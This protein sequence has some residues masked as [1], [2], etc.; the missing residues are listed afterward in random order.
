M[1]SYK[2][3][4][5]GGLYLVIDPCLGLDAILPKL[6]KAIEGGI[7]VLQIWNNWNSHQNKQELLD[8][9]CSIA[10]ANDIPV[11]IN[12]EWELMM[13]TALDGVHFDDIPSN[14]KAMQEVIGKP[15]ICGITCGNDLSRVHWAEENQ[16]DYISFCSMFPSV[17]AGVC[18]I[19]R[20]EAVQQARQ[21]TSISIFLAGG[22][23]LENVNELADTGMDG[24]ALISA[25]MKA[26]DPQK[27]TQAFKN[28]LK[29]IKN[30]AAVTN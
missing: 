16:L 2:R 27:A 21:I 23:T 4:I 26:G 20:K 18:E 10:H 17:S 28:K 14:F 19:V 30:N 7:D 24:I 13:T 12:G 15:F 5:K 6:Q 29:T 3:N 9:I 22:I 11:I 8:S 25:I 1:N